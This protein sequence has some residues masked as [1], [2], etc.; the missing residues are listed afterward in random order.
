MKNQNR[1]NVLFKEEKTTNIKINHWNIKVPVV[2]VTH[3][4]DM[5][6]T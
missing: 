6:D 1:F 2:E 4:H 3:I 5:T